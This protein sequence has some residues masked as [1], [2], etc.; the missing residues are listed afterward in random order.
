[1][2]ITDYHAKYF[3]YELTRQ[4]RGGDVGRITQLLCDASV[5][6]VITIGG[7]SPGPP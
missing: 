2:A 7:A 5:D 1:M 3:A 6:P 4:R